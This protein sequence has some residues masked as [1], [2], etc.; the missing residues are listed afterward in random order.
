MEYWNLLPAGIVIATIA[1]L[2]GIGGG[3]VWV[4]YLIIFA[5]FPPRDAIMLSFA[6][7]AVGMGSAVIMYLRQKMIFWGLAF[8]ILPFVFFGMLTGSFLSQ[9]V[10]ESSVIQM[11][12][13]VFSMA[14]AIFFAFQTESYG[15]SLNRDSGV[16]APA[17]LRFSSFFMGQVSGFLSIGIG[18][19]LIPAIRSRLK[20]PMQNAVGTALIMN[21]FVALSGGVTHILLSE[22]DVSGFSQAF[23]FGG[24]GVFV[25][26][27]IG[28]FL[29]SR[30]DEYRLKELFIFL[31]M[32]IGL[33]MIYH[34]L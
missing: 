18:D 33:H 10:A 29:S 12:L 23:A 30:I 22:N 25:G 32:M 27:Q 19:L 26:A 31:L 13:G 8:S 3:V 34:S 7:Q 16:K 4:P 11:T 6:I 24:T 14:V 9:R 17:W 20:I 28:S 2:M 1:S 15:M 5:K 21:F